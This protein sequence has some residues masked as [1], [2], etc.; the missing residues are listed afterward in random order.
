[1]VGDTVILLIL[2]RGLPANDCQSV[3]IVTQSLT[4][5]DAYATAV[6]VM[7]PEQGM[8]WVEEH[9]GVEALIVDRE[10]RAHRSSGWSSLKRNG[11]SKETPG[12][13]H[14]GYVKC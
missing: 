12:L 3:T 10:G 1:M 13:Q 5:A 8:Q 11:V 14:R 9:Q 2:T 4:E 6:Y 7:G